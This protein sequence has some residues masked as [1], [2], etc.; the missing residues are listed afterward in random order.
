LPHELI[1]GRSEIVEN[2]ADEDAES[3]RRVECWL[4]SGSQPN[5]LLAG[6]RVRFDDQ[7]VLLLLGESSRF[8][9]DGFEMIPGP[10]YLLPAAI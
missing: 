6:L 9:V 1:E 5:D 7:G 4:A 8:A 10:R 2:V 3:E